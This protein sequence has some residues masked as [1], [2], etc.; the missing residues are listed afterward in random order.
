MSMERVSNRNE[1][2]LSDTNFDLLG[3]K[4]ELLNTTLDDGHSDVKQINGLLSGFGGGL[5]QLGDSQARTECKLGHVDEDLTSVD[6]M[7]SYLV[8]REEV[9]EGAEREQQQREQVRML[10][11]SGMQSRK[12]KKEAEEMEV[13]E[14]ESMKAE[15]LARDGGI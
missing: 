7:L 14:I 8:E 11:E 12:R 13:R 2:A 9:R 15:R 3:A 1:P 4:L 10:I 6:L 5:T